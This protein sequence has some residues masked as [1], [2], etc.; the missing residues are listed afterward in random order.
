[1]LVL[2]DAPN[3]QFI[4]DKIFRISSFQIY[5]AYNVRQAE[6]ALQTFEPVA[7]VMDLVLAGEEAW[8]FL[9]RLKRD[10]RTR[11]VPVVIVSAVARQ[12][13]ALALGAD[14]YLVKPVDRRALLDT[15]SGLQARTS[16]AIRV[17]SIDDDPMSRYLLKQCLTTPF[18]DVTEASSGDEGIARAQADRPDV[19]LL[20]LIMPNKDG[21]ETLDDLRRNPMTRDIP[22]VICT[23]VELNGEETRTLL[24]HASAILSKRNLTRTSAPAIVRQTMDATRRFT[25]AQKERVDGY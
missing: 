24:Q 6:D 18:F 4:Y 22:V 17:L 16:A 2:E 1:L 8:D 21:R 12:E 15:I 20:D 19:I 3:D 5:P 23:G 13:K 25:H 11:Q 14:A 7:I 10:E 9:V